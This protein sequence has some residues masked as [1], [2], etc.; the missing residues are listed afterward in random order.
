[1]AEKTETQSRHE[2]ASASEK[3]SAHGDVG[4]FVVV[5]DGFGVADLEALQAK[6]NRVV[7]DR[8]FRDVES[9]AAY[10]ERFEKPESVALSDV[11]AATI[12]VMIDYHSVTDGPSHADHQATFDAVFTPEYKAWRDKDGVWQ[13]QVTAGLFLEERSR[14]VVEPDS[15]S[16]MDMVMQFDALKKVTFRQS[17]RLHDG[18]R[19]FTYNEENEVRGNVTLPE[20]ITLLVSVFEGQEPDRVP[21]RVRYRIE[22]G[23]LLFA[24]E[25]HERKRVEQL[26]FERCEDRLRAVRADLL[27]LRGK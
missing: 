9:L 10:L 12:R 23:S 20:R 2:F 15:A 18:Q 16:I 6:P 26:A 1:M 7:A 22:D 24:F 8:V 21:V 4:A 19:Q 11:D 14:D 3:L 17:T 27:F 5:P 25:I 13:K